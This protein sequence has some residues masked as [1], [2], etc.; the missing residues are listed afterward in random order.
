MNLSMLKTAFILI[1]VGL[2]ACNN[3]VED[4]GKPD[5]VET[6]RASN[7]LFN[8]FPPTSKEYKNELAKRIKSHPEQMTYIFDSYFQENGREYLQVQ[9][10]GG[11]FKAKGLILVNSWHKL[12]G[13]KRTKGQSYSGAELKG[14]Q[15]NII[16]SAWGADLIYKD[17][18]E[19]VD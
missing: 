8:K 10:E 17:L 16:P 14:L 11:D 4:D 3:T 18:E 9:V 12:E 7:T 6:N 19:I 2:S 1:C 13:I 5:F 15:L